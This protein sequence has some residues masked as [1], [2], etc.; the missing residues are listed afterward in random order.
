MLKRYLPTGL[1]GRTIL[2]I[3]IPVLLLQLTASIV[4][5]D[6]HWEKMTERLAG[7]VAGEIAATLNLIENSDSNIKAIQKFSQSYF[8][9]EFKIKALNEPDQIKPTRQSSYIYRLFNRVEDELSR[10]LYVL[11]DYEHDIFISEKDKQ[12]NVFIY[13]NDRLIEFIIPERRLFSSSSYIFLLWLIG[14][15]VLF[16]TIA[17]LFMRNQIRPIY[18]LGIAAERLGRGLPIGHIKPSGARE[19]RLATAAFIDMQ[20]RI[21]QF[22][23]Q[24]TTMLAAVSHDLKTP[25]TRMRLQLEMMEESPEKQDFIN[26]IHDMELMIESYLAFAK[27]DTV[28]TSQKIVIETLAQ[29]LVSNAERLGL[30]TT[31]KNK[32]NEID[33]IW[34]KPQALNR[35]FD[36][37]IGNAARYGDKILIS[38]R[39]E[40]DIIIIEI[41]DN[42]EGVDPRFINDLTKPFF[43]VETSRNAKTGGAGLGL[44]IAHDIITSHGGQMKFE[45]SSYLGGLHVTVYL[46]L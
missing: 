38:F 46:P 9:I 4:F 32:L 19:V 10:Q 26:D 41:E 31:L 17:L 14:L 7:A 43:R 6:R 44:A 25:L 45:R 39:Q 1:L 40:K 11:T 16:F 34:G 42:G 27:D 29:K 13:Q 18:R 3:L 5:F 22:I 15:S 28:E 24:R 37:I 30:K 2:I 36:N 33:F 35:V 8:N 12:I 21:E 20:Q 23:S